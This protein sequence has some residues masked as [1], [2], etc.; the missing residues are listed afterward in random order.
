MANNHQQF[1][2]FNTIIKLNSSKRESLKTSRRS[3]REK[4]ETHIHEKKGKHIKFEFH[5]QGSFETDTIIEP[6]PIT[7]KEGGQEVIKLKYDI[8]D[9]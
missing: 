2:E 8:D 3:L 6:I 5:G 9:G 1:G 7:V 4:I